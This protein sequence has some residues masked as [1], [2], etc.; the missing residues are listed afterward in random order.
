MCGGN[1]PRNKQTALT[2][3]FKKNKKHTTLRATNGKAHVERYA[4]LAVNRYA[5]SRLRELLCWQYGEE[6]ESRKFYA[7]MCV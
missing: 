6:E 5:S 4:L 7:L 2:Y 1:H 3:K